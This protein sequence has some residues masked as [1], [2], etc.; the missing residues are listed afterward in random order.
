MINFIPLRTL[1]F[2]PGFLFHFPPLPPDLEKFQETFPRDSS[3]IN[4]N[5]FLET[6]WGLKGLSVVKSVVA[7]PGITLETQKICSFTF[8]AAAPLAAPFQRRVSYQRTNLCCSY[9]HG[10]TNAQRSTFSLPASVIKTIFLDLITEHT[11][12]SILNSHLIYCLPFN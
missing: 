10:G 1:S 5:I 4:K 9:T 8:T 11:K 7:L 12:I 3:K 6:L 2:N